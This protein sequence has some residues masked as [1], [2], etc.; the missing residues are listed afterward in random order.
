MKSNLKK[1][2]RILFLSTLIVSCDKTDDEP[3]V[4]TKCDSTNT[5]FKQLYNQTVALTSPV[6]NQDNVTYDSEIHSYTFEV[7]SSKRICSV[8][9]QSQPALS[10]TP[11][12]IEVWDETPSTPLLVGTLSATFSS[13]TTSYVAF[14][15]AIPLTV[16]NNY[17][18]K[19]I[20]TNWGTN[21]GNTIGRMVHTV[22]GAP[23]SAFPYTFGSLKITGS[24]LYQNAGTMTDWAIP[25]I[26]IV[27]E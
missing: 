27:F 6:P 2:A 21:I 23:L 13:T 24:S 7:T 9:Y 19:R 8:G 25:F 10:S 26:D 11:Y 22:T 15:T 12:K 4:V 18:I 14:P 1:I 3:V 16:G 17:K 5:D 20:Q